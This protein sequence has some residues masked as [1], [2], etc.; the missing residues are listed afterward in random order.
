M[1]R[2]QFLI[3]TCF[4]FS[5]IFPP[6]ALS[7]HLTGSLILPGLIAPGDFNEDGNLDLAVNSTGFDHVA[8][9]LG[10]GNGG[11]TLAGHFA[12]DTVP[13][14][15]QVGDVNGDGHLDVIS[16]T[17]WGYDEIVL[18]GDGAGAFH[19]ISP[20]NEIDGD[21]EPVRLLLRDLNK[22]GWLDIAVSS[23]DDNKIQIYLGDGNG[24]FPAPP[25]EVEGVPKPFS[26]ASGD[27]N[28]D[29]NLDMAIVCPSQPAGGSEIAILLGDGTGNF[30]VSSVPVLGEPVSV[31]VGDINGDGKL[32]LVMSG[33]QPRNS[34]GNL[35]STFLGDGTGQF[36]LKQTLKLGAGYSKG[37]IALGD[38]NEDGNLD[39]AFPQT[40]QGMPGNKVLIFF[41]D[42]TGAL[43]AG[44]VLTVGQEP[45][46]VISVDLNHDGHLDLAVSNSRDGT[47]SALLGDGHGNF[48]L[49]STTS[50]LSPL[51]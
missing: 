24:N 50:I 38:F 31:Q 42:G 45:H 9:L 16:C 30:T 5:A 19:S 40:S 32:D 10:D 28:G 6:K 25:L 36:S 23:S 33:S 3:L 44:P 20:P 11:F 15:L 22:D 13:K 18:L 26:M 1:K 29:G 48:T 8:I 14:G 7:T 39:V 21:G 34:S 2:L 47:V 37:D 43:T 35:I 12:T 4:L 49:S 27:L 41:G 51:P 46:T 17:T